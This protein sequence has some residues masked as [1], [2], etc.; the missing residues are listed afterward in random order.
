M[1]EGGTYLSWLNFSSNIWERKQM[2]KYCALAEM[3]AL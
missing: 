2:P 3:F 1:N